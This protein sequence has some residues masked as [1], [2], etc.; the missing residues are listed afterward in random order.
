M[1]RQ[2]S[3]LNP[4]GQ[5]TINP[6][7][8]ITGPSINSIGAE[9]A[10]S[11]CHASPA[12]ILLAGRTES[13]IAPVIEQMNALN[14]SVNIK[15]IKVDLASQASI[16]SAAADTNSL[17]EKMWCLL[18]FLNPQQSRIYKIFWS[19]K[20]RFLPYVV[21]PRKMDKTKSDSIDTEVRQCGH[22]SYDIN[23]VEFVGECYIT[24]ELLKC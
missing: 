22:E 8:L 21:C 14:P 10:I 7:V 3:I 15:F 24:K 1:A 16:R 13:K 9:T 23:Y 20:D 2:V 18:W 6:S 5:P 4:Y 11:L 19:L 12:L 17:V